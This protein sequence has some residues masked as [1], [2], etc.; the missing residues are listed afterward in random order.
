M[1]QV[2]L[3]IPPRLTVHVIRRPGRPLWCFSSCMTISPGRSGVPPPWP[4]RRRNRILGIPSIGQRRRGRQASPGQRV[5]WQ[6]CPPPSQFHRFAQGHSILFC[7]SFPIREERQ[8]IGY[9]VLCH[10]TDVR[11]YPNCS[12]LIYY[13]LR[14]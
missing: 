13:F 14:F 6:S 11:A 5:G 2:I 8:V 7:S 9:P 1:Q 4:R 12:H 10:A 3:Q